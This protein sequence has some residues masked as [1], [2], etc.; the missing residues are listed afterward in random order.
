ME[1]P[2]IPDPIENFGLNDLDVHEGPHQIA[3]IY[4][5]ASAGQG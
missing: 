5:V 4:L 1:C 3:G 2:N